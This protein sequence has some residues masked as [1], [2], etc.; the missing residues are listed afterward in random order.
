VRTENAASTQIDLD[1]KPVGTLGAEGAA[2]VIEFSPGT[3][4]LREGG[5]ADDCTKGL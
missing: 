4:R 1:G 5:E 2:K 3:W